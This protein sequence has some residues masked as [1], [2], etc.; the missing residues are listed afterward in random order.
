MP[1]DPQQAQ[2]ED[3][4]ERNRQ[5]RAELRTLRREHHRLRE[6]LRT[7]TEESAVVSEESSRQRELFQA[8][9]R[10]RKKAP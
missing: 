9:L 1:D 2:Y 4:M 7:L 6:R 8:A 10:V 3:V 5:L